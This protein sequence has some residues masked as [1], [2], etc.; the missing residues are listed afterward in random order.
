MRVPRRLV[1][2][3]AVHV[4]VPVLRR[5]HVP[6]LLMHPLSVPLAMLVARGMHVPGPSMTPPDMPPAL[7][8][9][10]VPMPYPV[11][12]MDDKEAVVE[13]SQSRG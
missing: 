9:P 6:G 3:L 7:M 8:V 2:L 12:A 13:G 1:N 5:M 4:A 11:V 10:R